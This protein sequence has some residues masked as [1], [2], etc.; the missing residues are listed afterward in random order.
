M[1]LAATLLWSMENIIAKKVLKNISSELAALSRM[2]IGS[3]FLLL[4]V[5]FTRKL[6]VLLTINNQQLTIILVGGTI[7]SFYVF[8]W[9]KALKFAPVSL[10]T[11]VLTF[12]VVV[13][14]ILN[15]S[16]AGVKILPNDIISSTIILAATIFIIFS[17][18]PLKKSING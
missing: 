7:L 11:L 1:I 15:G 14:N 3:S 12:S 18:K 2:V 8:F 4:S 16:F 9:Y 10:V 6:N 5:L 13:G 17:L